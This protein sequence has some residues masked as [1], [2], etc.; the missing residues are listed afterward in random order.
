MCLQ[1]ETRQQSS[2]VTSAGLRQRGACSIL[3]ARGPKYK[4]H[5]NKSTNVKSQILWASIRVPLGILNSE[6]PGPNSKWWTLW[7]PYLFYQRRAYASFYQE[8]MR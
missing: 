8:G 7:A 2:A 3:K 6:N 4:I 1:T 5:F